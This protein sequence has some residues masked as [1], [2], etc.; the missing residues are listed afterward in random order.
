MPNDED[1]G[2]NRPPAYYD[3]DGTLVLRASAFGGSCLWE[4]VAAAQGYEATILPSNMRRA[5]NEGHRL[6]PE[7]LRRLEAEYPVVLDHQAAQR[8]GSLELAK[9]LI[10]RF[11]PDG[12]GRYTQPLVGDVFLGKPELNW[13]VVVEVKALSHDL[14][15]KAVRHGVESTIG[16]YRWQASVMMLATHKRLLWVVYNKG[17]PPDKDTGIKPFCEDQGKIHLQLVKTPFVSLSEMVLKGLEVKELVEGEDILE[18]GRPCDDP[19]HWPCR[20]LH[21]RPESETEDGDT[22]GRTDTTRGD[23]ERKARTHVEPDSQDKVDELVKS[24]L[25]NKGQAD[26]CKARADQ[27]RDE[28]LA[29]FGGQ[30]G[31]YETDRFII[32]VTQGRGQKALAWDEMPEEVKTLVESYMRPGKPYLYLRGVKGKA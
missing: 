4:L 24:Y 6:E 8:E 3:P 26:E 31:T 20:Y 16:E 21:L 12:A 5:F 1:G 15:K 7:V 19:S 14:W 2:D 29:I 22:E 25:Y 11:H 9:G 28:L 17:Y 13:D 32:P 10:V 18:S 27:A 30:K 23:S